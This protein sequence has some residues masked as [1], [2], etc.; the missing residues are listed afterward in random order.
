MMRRPPRSTLF[1]Y[2]TLFRSARRVGRALADHCEAR[3][4]AL[5]TGVGLRAGPGRLVA[6]RAVRGEACGVA[7]ARGRER[8]RLNSTHAHI[9][10][11]GFC[12]KKKKVY[13]TTLSST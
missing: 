13:T 5:H 1:P 10:F 2:T 9:S 3:A 8:K 11:S 4:A 6:L 7:P 12:F